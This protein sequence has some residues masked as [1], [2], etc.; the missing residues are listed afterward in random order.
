MTGK[1]IGTQTNGMGLKMTNDSSAQALDLELFSKNQDKA[2]DLLHKCTLRMDLAK[3]FAL[4]TAISIDENNIPKE[5]IIPMGVALQGFLQDIIAK[6][7]NA[8][9][10]T[11]VDMNKTCQS[12]QGIMLC[13]RETLRDMNLS[14]SHTS[15]IFFL[16]EDAMEIFSEDVDALNMEVEE[17]KDRILDAYRVSKAD[18]KKITAG[19][20]LKQAANEAVNAA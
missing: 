6:I 3:S 18:T 16:V 11:E 9:K 2:V 15:N 4:R 14:K 20:G 1:W 19:P 17:S 5:E 8:Q 12:I 7:E 10:L 13:L